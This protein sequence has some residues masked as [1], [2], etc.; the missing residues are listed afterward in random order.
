[1]ENLVDATESLERGKPVVIWRVDVVFLEKAD[2][3]YEK[4]TAGESGGGRTH[5]FGVRN[6][7]K[8][9]SGKAIYR[10]TDVIVR[11]GKP[12]PGNGNH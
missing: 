11:D 6:P 1:M 8:K 3:K 5:T 4:S 7:A 9:L 10:R 2:W 12:I